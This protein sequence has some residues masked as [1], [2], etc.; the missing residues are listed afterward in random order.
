IVLPNGQHEHAVS[1]LRYRPHLLQLRWSRRRRI[2]R[3]IIVFGRCGSRNGAPVE[4]QPVVSGEPAVLE[5]G[6]GLG[7]FGLHAQP[8][9]TAS[10]P[11]EEARLY[12]AREPIAVLH[13]LAAPRDGLADSASVI[14]VPR[15]QPIRWR[16]GARLPVVLHD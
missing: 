14:G 11:I 8:L 16:G 5:L 4:D 9:L 12:I 3:R 6:A 10:L 7:G 15:E 1:N 13:G 2:K